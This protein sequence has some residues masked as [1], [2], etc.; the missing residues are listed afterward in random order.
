MST[1]SS[2]GYEMRVV[3]EGALRHI[4][5]G[6]PSYTLPVEISED[7]RARSARQVS[8]DNMQHG[9]QPSKHTVVK[10]GPKGVFREV[11]L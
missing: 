8:F 7:P 11:E 1:P 5:S 3:E 9:Y 10:Q 2:R 6:D 4:E